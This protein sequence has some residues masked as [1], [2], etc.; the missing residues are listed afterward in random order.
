M[1]IFISKKG[2]DGLPADIDCYI[3]YKV[4]HPRQTD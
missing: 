3:L 4:A 2:I 1:F